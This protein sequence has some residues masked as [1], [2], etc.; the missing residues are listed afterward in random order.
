MTEDVNEPRPPRAAAFWL[1][2]LGVLVADAVVWLVGSGYGVI[3]MAVAVVV[4]LGTQR[5]ADAY[6]RAHHS[7]ASQPVG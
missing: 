6:W 7:P 1:L 3:G 5:Q 4:I 2:A